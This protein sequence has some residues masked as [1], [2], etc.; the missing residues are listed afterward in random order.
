MSDDNKQDRSPRRPELPQGVPPKANKAALAVFLS[1]LVLFAS[2]FLFSEKTQA[3]QIPY[4]A[5]LS[6]VELGE[7]DTVQIV[8]QKEIKGYL[9]AVD[10]SLVEFSTS[11]PYFD[12]ELLS[13]LRGKNVKSLW[14]RGGS[15]HPYKFFLNL[16]HGFLAFSLSG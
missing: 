1:L 4:S 10:G 15:V 14:C 3:R 9:K 7:V 6:Y 5:F 2:F 11:I 13:Q 12:L 8:D 16:H